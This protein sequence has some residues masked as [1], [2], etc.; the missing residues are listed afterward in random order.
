MGIGSKVTIALLD[1]PRRRWIE[2][3]SLDLTVEPD[4]SSGEHMI[5]HYET[6]ER[7]D[8]Y[9]PDTVGFIDGLNNITAPLPDSV[10]E[11]L[12]L[13]RK[14]QAVNLFEKEE[15]SDGGES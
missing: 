5:L 7:S 1:D 11:I 9:E 15:K 12:A 8:R 3:D 13:F 4:F 10:E 2:Q 6:G 14:R